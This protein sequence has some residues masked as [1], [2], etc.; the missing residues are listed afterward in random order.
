[1]LVLWC[2]NHKGFRLL[3][4]SSPTTMNRKLSTIY[5]L[6]SSASCFFLLVA[7]RRWVGAPLKFCHAATFELEFPVGAPVGGHAAVVLLLAVRDCH[8]PRNRPPKV[9]GARTAAGGEREGNGRGNSRGIR[10][11]AARS[12]FTSPSALHSGVIASLL[13]CSSSPRFPLFATIRH[14]SPGAQPGRAVGAAA[15]RGGTA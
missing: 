8:A 14:Y 11:A 2:L 7:C 13:M 4:P 5:P 9:M 1:M 12:T 6:P 3:F 10:R 15:R